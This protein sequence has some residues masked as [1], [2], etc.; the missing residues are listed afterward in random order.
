MWA[1]VSTCLDSEF[2]QP[3]SKDFAIFSKTVEILEAMILQIPYYS[4]PP[5]SLIPQKAY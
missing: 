1:M 4:D 3:A 5:T 2:T